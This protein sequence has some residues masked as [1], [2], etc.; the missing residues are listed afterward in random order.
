MKLTTIKNL[1]NNVYTVRFETE[2]TEAEIELVSDFGDPTV[3]MG[4]DIYGDTITYTGTIVLNQTITQGNARG[5]MIKD[6]TLHR[7]TTYGFSAGGLDGSAATLTA[8]ADVSY[9]LSIVNRN[10]EAGFPYTRS[11]T[12]EVN[13][14]IY[15]AE[16]VKRTDNVIIA[17]R[18]NSDTFSGESV[19]TL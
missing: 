18:A 6:G 19:V 5:Q 7:F 4:G 2:L 13:G 3:S 9:T 14:D 12:T 15:G 10:L 1:S 8:V 16:I 17:L 11:L